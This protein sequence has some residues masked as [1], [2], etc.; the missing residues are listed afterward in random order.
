MA[1]VATIVIVIPQQLAGPRRAGP[2]R[3][4]QPFLR[5]YVRVW[6]L[7]P[8]MPLTVARLVA[9]YG[10]ASMI[11]ILPGKLERF[12]LKK[13]QPRTQASYLDALRHFKSEPHSRGIVWSSMA[14]QQLEPMRCGRS[15]TVSSAAVTLTRPP[16][17][18][19]SVIAMNG[20]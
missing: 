2:P 5:N 19:C 12:L 13:L 14:C 16:N 1:A 3:P 17:R 7:L 4:W 18:I 6:P 15:G 20:S 9:P 8:L 11:G 10:V